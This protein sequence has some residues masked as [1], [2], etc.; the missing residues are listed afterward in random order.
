VLLTAGTIACQSTPFDPAAAYGIVEVRV[1]PDSAMISGEPSAFTPDGTVD[2]SIEL[3]SDSGQGMPLDIVPTWRSNDP[4]VA[5][6]SPYGTVVGRK[7]GTT[8]IEAIVGSV[9]GYTKV[10]VLPAIDTGITVAAHRGFKRVFPENTL[11]AIAGAYERGADAA[12]IDVRLTVDRVPV[13][14]HDPTV[15]RTTNGTGAVPFLTL[16][17]IK[18]LDACSKFGSSWMPCEVPT[19]QEAL[20]TARGHGILI[21]DLEGPYDSA[22][23][24]SVLKSVRSAGMERYVIITSFNYQLLEIVRGLDDVI[25]LGMLGSHMP[26]VPEVA[27]LGRAIGMPDEESLLSAPEASSALVSSAFSQNVDIMAWTVSTPEEAEKLVALGVRHI[28]S[29]VPLDKIALRAAAAGS[30][31]AP[32]LTH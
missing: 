11:V 19:L 2:L 5:T 29:D 20:D 10:T 6:V 23:L 9:R 15:D 14:M 25:P 8:T 31:P 21:L 1:V 18:Q 32:A 16:K 13:V 4:S 27:R 30:R 3:L 26:A 24:V 22:A 12:E 28:I 17:Q 7:A